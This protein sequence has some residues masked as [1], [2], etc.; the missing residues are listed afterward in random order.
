M[1]VL[2]DITVFPVGVGESV[3]QHVK[4]AVDRVKESGLPHRVGPMG[5]TVEGEFS[6]V[7]DVIAKCHHALAQHANRVYMVVKID[8]RKGPMGRLEAKVKAVE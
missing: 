1:S 3:H 4:K 7:M 8:S 5:T 2:A 6:Q